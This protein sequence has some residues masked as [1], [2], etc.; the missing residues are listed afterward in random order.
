MTQV[1][2]R[3]Q[4]LGEKIQRT[5]KLTSI[6]RHRNQYIAE[7]PTP[8]QLQYLRCAF[9]TRSK[10]GMIYLRVEVYFE[11]KNSPQKLALF[12]EYENSARAGS[13]EHTTHHSFKQI[14]LCTMI[15]FTAVYTKE[16]TALG[17]HPLR[18]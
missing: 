11:Y 6:F 4:N 13:F 10:A 5:S 17:P 8:L 7:M 1:L 9:S 15:I 2:S 12:D 16:I 14:I 18:K 3:K